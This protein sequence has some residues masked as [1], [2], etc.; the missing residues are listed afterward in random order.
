[1]CNS[2]K[3][4]IYP[5]YFLQS[6]DKQLVSRQIYQTLI[7]MI[8]IQN[9]LAQLQQVTTSA[10]ADSWFDTYLGKKGQLNEEFKTL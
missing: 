10:Q 4:A 6:Q 2:D 5:E 1:M 8:D 9:A 3:Q 7:V